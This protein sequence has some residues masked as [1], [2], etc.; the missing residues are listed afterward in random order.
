MSQSSPTL[1]IGIFGNVNPFSTFTFSSRSRV[2]TQGL[3]VLDSRRHVSQSP[4]SSPLINQFDRLPSWLENAMDVV[5]NPLIPELKLRSQDTLQMWWQQE[6]ENATM[7]SQPA[8]P[9]FV[10]SHPVAEHVVSSPFSPPPPSSHTSLFP[11]SSLPPAPT[12][13]PSPAD[14]A[15]GHAKPA[16]STNDEV[17]TVG[18]IV[19]MDVKRLPALLEVLHSASPVHIDC[20][21]SIMASEVHSTFVTVSVLPD[22]KINDES[23]TRISKPAEPTRING[24]PPLASSTL[25]NS[26]TNQSD[27]LVVVSAQPKVP[28]PPEPAATKEVKAEWI[29]D[30][31]PPEDASSSLQTPHPTMVTSE[32]DVRSCH[33][34]QPSVPPTITP[35]PQSPAPTPL[36]STLIPPPAVRLSQ[37]PPL[38]TRSRQFASQEEGEIPHLEEMPFSRRIDLSRSRVPCSSPPT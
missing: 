4:P 23:H 3:V 17:M 21:S 27:N 13:P 12:R 14:L 29:E 32:R 2:F 19:E 33:I 24:H 37:V 15:I 10:T 16:Q 1:E 18:D 7:V 31:I 11:P 26:K 20:S 36:L 8:T 5:S 9:P 25:H 6:R 35:V 30:D 22:A 28:P 38:N 34:L